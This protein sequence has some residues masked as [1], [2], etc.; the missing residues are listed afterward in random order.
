M[1]RTRWSAPFATSAP[2]EQAGRAPAQ[3]HQHAQPRIPHPLSTIDGAI[4]RL[5]STS[6]AAD[7]ATRQRYRKIQTAVDRLIGMMDEYLSPER[8]AEAGASRPADAASPAALLQ[9]AAELARAAGRTV[10]V[11]IGSL[12]S[13]AALPAER[14]A[15]GAQGPGRQ[16]TPVFAARSP[17][18]VQP[19]MRADGG[20]LL[21]LRDGGSGVPQDELAAIFGKRVRGTNAV[22]QGS[23]LGLYMAR[24]VIEV[25]G[26]NISAKKCGAFGCRIQNLVA[27]AGWNGEKCCILSE[28][29]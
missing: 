22:G 8:M 18:R 3:V 27:C 28:Q 16:C 14:L 24:S 26:G 2:R 19:S 10:S 12:L 4:Q 25:H 6:A 7:E 1:W 13:H 9:E 17:A 21:L 29:L 20:T 15:A 11:E 23:G 5:E